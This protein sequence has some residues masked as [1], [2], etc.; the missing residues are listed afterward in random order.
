MFIQTEPTPN[1]ATLKFLPGK[2]VL[3]D[4]TVDYRSKAEAAA[5]PLASRLFE[6]EGVTGV[7]LGS[8]FISV[9][10]GDVEWP[11][12]RAAVCRTVAAQVHGRSWAVKHG[13]LF[14]TNGRNSPSLGPALAH[15]PKFNSA[16]MRV[17]DGKVYI[18]LNNAVTQRG[19]DMNR[20]S[21]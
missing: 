21:I 16:L 1:P 18:A 13:C 7:F 5:S 10:K 17:A 20:I 9:T 6:I 4:G 11:H 2:A 19:Q 12:I 14:H 8:D 3:G 15:L